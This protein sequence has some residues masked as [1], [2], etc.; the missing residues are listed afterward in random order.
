MTPSRINTTTPGIQ[1][2][3]AKPYHGQ[4][5][6]RWS[7]ITIGTV[8]TFGHQARTVTVFTRWTSPG[9][10]L[11]LDMNVYF[12]HREGKLGGGAQGGIEVS[13]YSGE[14]MLSALACGQEQLRMSP[15][16]VTRAR[17]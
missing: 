16:N 3:T 5:R 17:R 4:A 15:T 13:S 14:V 1:P 10:P 9:H 12:P 8:A 11:F 7:A 2:M 6:A